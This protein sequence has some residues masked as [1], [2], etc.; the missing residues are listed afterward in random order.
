MCHNP[1]W[2]SASCLRVC[3]RLSDPPAA[4][5]WM[6]GFIAV[7]GDDSAYCHAHTEEAC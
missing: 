1:L 6:N 3:G 7:I 2:W 4:S 5:G